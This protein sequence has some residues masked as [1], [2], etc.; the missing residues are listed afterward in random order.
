M[1]AAGRGGIVTTEGKARS[2]V[3]ALGAGGVVGTAWM[4]GLVSALT[5]GGLNLAYADRI[6]GTSAGAIAGAWIASRQP[7]GPLATSPPG[8]RDSAPGDPRR[9]AAAVALMNESHGED[10]ADVLRRI[11][12]IA[13][14]LPPQPDRAAAAR[15]RPLLAA[16]TWP[17][18]ELL[19]TTVDADSGERRVWDRASG[20]LLPAAV[21]SSRAVPGLYPTVLVGGRRY[22]DGGM[23]SPTHLDLAENATALIVIEPLAH[24]FPPE[25]PPTGVGRLLRLAPDTDAVA[26]FGADLYNRSAWPVAYAEGARQGAAVAVDHRD[27]WTKAR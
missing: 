19:I 23:F 7:L 2:R 21:A 4:A 12:R 25:A 9:M 1:R 11:G 16:H 20:I 22:M 18:N 15:L 10:R 14:E 3:V 5:S 24:L 13:L 27:W 17:S 26:A 8:D 6:I